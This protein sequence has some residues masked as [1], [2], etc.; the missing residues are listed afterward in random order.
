MYLDLQE[1][2][3]VSAHLHEW[4]DLIFGYKQVGPEAAKACNVFNFYTYEDNVNLD[5]IKDI[6]E[7]QQI[8][9][10]I[11]NFGQTP[12]Q[13]FVDPH[14][15]RLPLD[16][17]RKVQARGFSASF[18]G[19]RATVNLFDHLALLKAHSVDFKDSIVFVG[20]PSIQ[21]RALLVSGNPEQLVR[22]PLHMLNILHGVSP[23]MLITLTHLSHIFTFVFM[24]LH[25]VHLHTHVCTYASVYI[26]INMLVVTALPSSC[27]IKLFVTHS[28]TESGCVHS[29]K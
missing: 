9:S 23:Q 16:T 11:S 1:S 24:Y 4:I 20:T 19:K 22:R 8:E 13:L 25:I 18:S 15:S 5:T 28:Y 3:Y 29:R 10:I 12:T 6:K 17:T 26:H 27:T 21:T 7:R 2:E 14:P